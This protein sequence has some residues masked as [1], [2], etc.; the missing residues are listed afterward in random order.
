MQKRYGVWC[1]VWGGVTG[2]R[3][4]WLKNSVGSPMEYPTLEA[5]TNVAAELNENTNGNEYRTADFRYT[6]RVVN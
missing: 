6:V 2:H 4:S 1:E 5:A 3:E